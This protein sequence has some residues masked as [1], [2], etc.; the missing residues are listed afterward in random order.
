MKRIAVLE[1]QGHDLSGDVKTGLDC[2]AKA[3]IDCNAGSG[4]S[5]YGVLWV[6]WDSDLPTALRVLRGCSLDVV[7][8]PLGYAKYS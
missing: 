1:R 7:E 3:K 8:A 5:G 4:G 6:H 2:L